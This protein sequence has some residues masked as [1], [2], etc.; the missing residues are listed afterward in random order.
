ML[1]SSKQNKPQAILEVCCADIPSIEAAHKGGAHRVEVCSSL[2]SG[3]VTPSVAAI[4]FART[5][6]GDVHVLIRPREGDFIYSPSEK[7]VIIN[8]I[9]HAIEAGAT[10][11]VIGALLPSGEIDIAFSRAM[12]EAAKGVNITFSRAFDLVPNPQQALETIINLGCTHLLT[13]GCAPTALEGIST[14][15]SLFKQSAGRIKIIAASGINSQ[16]ARQ[17]IEESGVSEIHASASRPIQSL[18]QTKS[19]VKMGSASAQGESSRTSTSAAEVRA[20]IQSIS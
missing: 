4:S 11:V 8:D 19:T 16:N 15:S 9:H 6:F 2:A 17:I 18:S 3:G 14:I 12:V 20:I 1:L 5:L 13:S 7:Q 10:G